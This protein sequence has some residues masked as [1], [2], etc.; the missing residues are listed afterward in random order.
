MGDDG[1]VVGG[2]IVGWMRFRQPAGVFTLRGM[3][4]TE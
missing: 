4:R 2:K 3:C 1:R